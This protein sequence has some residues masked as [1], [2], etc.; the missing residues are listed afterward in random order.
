MKKDEFMELIGK[1]LAELARKKFK[2]EFTSEGKLY[3]EGL[4][5]GAACFAQKVI[6]NRKN[7]EKKEFDPSQNN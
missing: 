5:D 4:M 1:D 7:Q 2:G 3:A 6:D